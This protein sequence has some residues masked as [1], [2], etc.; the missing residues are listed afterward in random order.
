MVTD[1]EPRQVP[2]HR[3]VRICDGGRVQWSPLRFEIYLS[4]GR[5]ANSRNT[6]QGPCLRF[7]HFYP[8]LPQTSLRTYI[9]LDI[10]LFIYLLHSRILLY[11]V[12]VSR[13]MYCICRIAF[14]QSLRERALRRKISTKLVIVI[15][16]YISYFISCNFTSQP[17]SRIFRFH[18]LDEQINYKNKRNITTAV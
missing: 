5:L 8:N 16:K 9:H 6:G 13:D 15:N 3:R 7:L 17:D 18:E 10:Y 11:S 12:D 14:I 4:N 2:S 1:T